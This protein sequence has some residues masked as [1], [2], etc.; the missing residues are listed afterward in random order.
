MY[1][2]ATLPPCVSNVQYEGSF[3]SEYDTESC[4][5]RPFDSI[6]FFFKTHG[7]VTRY[8][9]G[10]RAFS[11]IRVYSTTEFLH[12]Y[13]CHWN[14]Y[15]CLYGLNI[16]VAKIKTLDAI[17]EKEIV[18]ECRKH[19]PL[20]IPTHN[21]CFLCYNLDCILQIFVV[22]LFYAWTI[23]NVFLPFCSSSLTFY[24]SQVNCF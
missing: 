2:A 14:T 8:I 11:I 13:S 17:W 12:T 6:F 24:C 22:K 18:M 1:A 4:A 21:R 23:L 16:C 5:L 10:P 15:F 7:L 20:C 19:S 3:P 9:S